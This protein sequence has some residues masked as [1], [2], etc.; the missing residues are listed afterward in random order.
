MPNTKSYIAFWAVH[1]SAFL[2]SFPGQHLLCLCAHT[3]T[4]HKCWDFASSLACVIGFLY[5]KWSLPTS[6]PAGLLVWPCTWIFILALASIPI[7]DVWLTTVRSNR[8]KKVSSPLYC[9]P[10][11]WIIWQHL[12]WSVHTCFILVVVQHCSWFYFTCPCWW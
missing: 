11:K 5:K 3:H 6:L 4:Q 7:Q 12:V 2:H 9:L 10:F 1:C 8:W